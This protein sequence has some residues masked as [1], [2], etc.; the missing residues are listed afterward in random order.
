MKIFH[1]YLTVVVK[2]FLITD[3]I[4]SYYIRKQPDNTTAAVLCTVRIE[5]AS[6]LEL[7][8]IKYYLPLSISHNRLDRLAMLSTTKKLL[9]FIAQSLNATDDVKS[10]LQF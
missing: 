6:F 10:Y 1:S 3:M 4:K 9:T 7:K 5:E 2:F 8:I